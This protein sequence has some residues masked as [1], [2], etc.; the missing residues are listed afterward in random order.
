MTA[1]WT[2]FA[3]ALAAAAVA[4][5]ALGFGWLATPR[6]AADAGRVPF[7]AGGEIELHAWNRYHAR[8]YA[9][10]LLFLAFDMEMVYMY[11]WAVVFQEIGLKA[12]A[13]MGIFISILLLGIVY[14]WKEG[15]LEWS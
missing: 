5:V 13:E 3:F 9:L 12:L 2:V 10:A 4:L 14:A 1:Y 11:P 6:D 15:A 7:V 8:Y